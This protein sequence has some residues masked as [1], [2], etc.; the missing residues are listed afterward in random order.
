MIFSFLFIFP[1]FPQLDVKVL[2]KNGKGVPFYFV[3]AAI[4][5]EKTNEKSL[6]II[7][8]TDLGTDGSPNFVVSD[9]RVNYNPFY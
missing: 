8:I 1:F 4:E 3:Y 7:D 5:P 6:S 2:D 9:H